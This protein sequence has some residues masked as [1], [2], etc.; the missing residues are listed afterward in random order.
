MKKKKT[1]QT[2]KHVKAFLL[3][4]VALWRDRDMIL[5]NDEWSV[6]CL[7]KTGW[8]RPYD[9]VR[10]MKQWGSVIPCDSVK[11]WTVT[12]WDLAINRIQSYSMV[13]CNAELSHILWFRDKV[14]SVIL[15]SNKVNSVILYGSVIKWTQPYSMVQWNTVL[16]TPY[17]SQYESYPDAKC[18]Y[19]KSDE[20]RIFFCFR[21]NSYNFR[22]WL[23]LYFY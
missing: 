18:T 19:T 8:A 20:G 4:L 11:C 14:N 13:K 17:G 16:I 7:G 6:P 9:G 21:Y 10:S 2:G 3:L 23:C 15:Y 12:P 1:K 22:V 5:K